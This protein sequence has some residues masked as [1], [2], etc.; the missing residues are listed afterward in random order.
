MQR[1]SQCDQRIQ[2][3]IWENGT[4][5]TPAQKKL[6]DQ[7]LTMKE[8]A[9]ECSTQ[10]VGQ[11]LQWLCKLTHSRR[12]L[13]VGCLTGVNTV[14]LALATPTDGQVLTIDRTDKHLNQ[15]RQWWKE[16][17]VDGRVI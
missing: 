7:T 11:C 3:Y 6:I 1:G 12:V 14:A 5:T 15:C 10:D 17:G 2:R 13:E 9:T 16:A 4:R 8:C